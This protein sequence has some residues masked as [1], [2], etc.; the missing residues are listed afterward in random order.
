MVGGG[1][2]R[3]D[4]AA[5][6]G[7]GRFLQGI[8][9]GHRRL[10]G[11]SFI[12]QP[13]TEVSPMSARGPGSTAE[14]GRSEFCAEIRQFS[15]NHSQAAGIKEWDVPKRV[16]VGPGPCPGASLLGGKPRASSRPGWTENPGQGGR[17]GK[18][19]ATSKLWARG[20]LGSD[21]NRP[22]QKTEEERARVN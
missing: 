20:F 2:P 11:Y 21:A 15:R 16:Q 8:S 1:R 6:R 4:R 13:V 22:G 17:W 10:T 5:V 3:P 9:M 12:P 7:P 19:N 14:L 18:Q